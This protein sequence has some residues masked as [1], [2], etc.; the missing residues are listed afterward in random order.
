MSDTLR[1]YYS[2]SAY[3]ITCLFDREIP[4]DHKGTFYSWI[5]E[6]FDGAFSKAYGR[7]LSESARAESEGNLAR[8]SYAFIEFI[9]TMIGFAPEYRKEKKLDET[10][11]FL[12]SLTK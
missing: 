12:D 5:E 1:D 3:E 10:E 6:S 11:I 2:M 8:Q 9:K 4:D 7:F